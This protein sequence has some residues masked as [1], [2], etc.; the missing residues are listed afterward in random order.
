MTITYTVH[1]AQAGNTTVN[2]DKSAKIVYNVLESLQLETLQED[3][4]KYSFC[5]LVS[6]LGMFLGN[7][8]LGFQ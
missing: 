8:C 2:V 6:T 1:F 3:T 7:V 4:C 5:M